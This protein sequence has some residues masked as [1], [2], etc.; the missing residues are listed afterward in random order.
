MIDQ[1]APIAEEED[2]GSTPA[3]GEDEGVFC[4]CPKFPSEASRTTDIKGGITFAKH[5]RPSGGK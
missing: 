3:G 1:N 4:R 5:T 2:G